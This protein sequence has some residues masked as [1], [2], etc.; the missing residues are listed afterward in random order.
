MLGAIGAIE[1][2][3]DGP[4]GDGKGPRNDAANDPAL[5]DAAV[6][7]LA[8]EMCVPE[9]LFRMVIERYPE[10]NRVLARRYPATTCTA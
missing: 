3:T 1:G 10:L 7:D 8:Q 9:E 6:A 2:R 4:Q 5:S